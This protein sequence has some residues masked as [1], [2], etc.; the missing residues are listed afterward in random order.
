M[1]WGTTATVAMLLVVLATAPVTAQSDATSLT[2]TAGEATPGETVTLTFEFANNGDEPIA[3]IVSVSELPDDWTVQ[4]HADDGGVWRDDR[5]WLF[6]S[7][8]A[9]G[10]VAPSITVAVPDDATDPVTVPGNAM[11]GNETVTGQT[12]VRVAESQATATG[13]SSQTP[14]G[15]SDSSGPG[16]GVGTALAAALGLA[17]V[18]GRSQ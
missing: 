17:L 5:S 16:F 10:S 13:E 4:S 1:R 8:E 6:Q 14:T 2:A 15:T 9:G 7:V 18:I 11:V 3:T 12:T